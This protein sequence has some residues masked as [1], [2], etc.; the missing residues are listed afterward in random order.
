VIDVARAREHAEQS[1]LAEVPAGCNPVR[2][3]LSPSGDTAYVTAR[4]GNAVNVFATAALL[5]DPAH[6]RVATVP[7]GKSPVG[8][9]LSANGARLIVTNSDRFGPDRSALETLSIIDTK[10]VASGAAAVTGSIPA[11]AFP[12]ELR[13]TADGILMVTNYLSDSVQFVPLK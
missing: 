13:F 6:A 12:R 1:V 8:M 11:G 4:G 2:V 9:A 10:A 7:T 3:A 5:A